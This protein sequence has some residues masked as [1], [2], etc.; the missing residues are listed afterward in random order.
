MLFR[1][2]AMA[3][4]FWNKK[5]NKKPIKECFCPYLRKFLYRLLDCCKNDQLEK[6]IKK[7]REVLERNNKR[8]NYIDEHKED[9][10]NAVN[11]LKERIIYLEN[12]LSNC[13]KSKRLLSEE[14]IAKECFRDELF[15]LCLEN[16]KENHSKVS[17]LLSIISTKYFQLELENY[18]L[19][20]EKNK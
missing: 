16:K 2:V 12:E 14:H 11:S 15:Q 3:L 10:Y 1:S 6:D 9:I 5:D 20:D 13:E 7:A 17:H 19:F 4:L 8:M 18:Q